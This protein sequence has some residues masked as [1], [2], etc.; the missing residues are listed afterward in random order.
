MKKK[1]GFIGNPA[2]A[3]N[4]NVSTTPHIPVSKLTDVNRLQ[5]FIASLFPDLP[6]VGD[7]KGAHI[8][9]KGQIRQ[10]P[11]DIV[12]LQGEGMKIECR[13]SAV[14]EVYDDEGYLAI[15]FRFFNGE[16]QEFYPLLF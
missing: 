15:R 1:V 10:A 12:R 16:G 14:G 2:S 11:G 5:N 6:L 3:V 4:F 13:M 7:L 8:T 9:S